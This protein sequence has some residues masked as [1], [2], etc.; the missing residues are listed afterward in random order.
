MRLPSSQGKVDGNLLRQ[1]TTWTPDKGTQI[2]SISIVE[3]SPPDRIDF[4][5][6]TMY[7]KDISDQI[8]IGLHNRRGEESPV[9]CT[10]RVR[11][12]KPS[13]VYPAEIKARAAII[14]EAFAFAYDVINASWIE[15]EDKNILGD[16]NFTYGEVKF[17]SFYPLL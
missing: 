10:I 9:D 5:M 3:D 7:W 4:I 15:R 16:R 12:F 17:H 2:E 8:N 11:D 14:K 13:D 1:L 6:S